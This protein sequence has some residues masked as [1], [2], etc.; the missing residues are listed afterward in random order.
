[1][2]GG[3]GGGW[4]WGMNRPYRSDEQQPKVELT[5]AGVRRVFG[6]LAPYW[7]HEVIILICV[8]AM[9]GLGLIPPL[10]MRGVIDTAIPAKDFGLLNLLVFGMVALPFLSGLIGVLQSY[11]NALVGQR[12]V[13]RPA[14]AA[15]PAHAA[16]V[17]ALLHQDPQ[18]RDHL[19]HQ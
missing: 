17:T 5:A 19:P 3:G 16:H 1:M 14:Q 11:L 10:L 7:P 6:Y 12:I 13:Y 18:R 9:T 15:F 4:S 8:L 2:Y